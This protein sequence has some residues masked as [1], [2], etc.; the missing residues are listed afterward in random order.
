MAL[1]D[2]LTT[3]KAQGKIW[4]KIQ[5]LLSPIQCSLQTRGCNTDPPYDP[6]LPGFDRY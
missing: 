4:N 6:N 3:Q 2:E 5:A 1:T